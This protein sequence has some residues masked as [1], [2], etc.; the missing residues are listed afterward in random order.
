VSCGCWR[1]CVNCFG[2]SLIFASSICV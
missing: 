1:V 2:F